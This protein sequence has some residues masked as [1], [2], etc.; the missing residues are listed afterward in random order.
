MSR[1]SA[2][3]AE[4][5]WAVAAKLGTG[6]LQFAIILLMARMLS[7]EELGSFEFALRTM[8]VVLVVSNL[9]LTWKS[10][11]LTSVGATDDDRVDVGAELSILIGAAL[12]S[13]TLMSIAFIA[14]LTITSGTAFMPGLA[15]RV[16]LT[17]MV[18][19]LTLLLVMSEAFRGLERIREASLFSGLFSNTL[20][21]VVIGGYYLSL[22]ELSVVSGLVVLSTSA[23]VAASAAYLTLRRVVPGVAFRFRGIE[24]L[25]QIR[26]S[27]P[28][29][30][31][32]TL[33]AVAATLDI[34]AVKLLLSAESLGQYATA[35]RWSLLF[36]IPWMI[37]SAV[38]R[39]RLAAA[40]GRKEV[41]KV[42]RIVGA[43]AIAIGL[44][45][46]LLVL[47][48]YFA[49]G[50]LLRLALPPEFGTMET[51]LILL[52]VAYSIQST[53]SFYGL[54]LLLSGRTVFTVIVP[55][56]QI[57][58]FSALVHPLATHF[59]IEGVAAAM[60]VAITAASSLQVGLFATTFNR[61]G[62][63]DKT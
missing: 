14:F 48:L 26:I 46:G 22:G 49:D 41:S 56:S 58:V 35:A 4:V 45:Q 38:F 47:L 30:V 24:M 7:L 32:N 6:V 55:L 57:A 31:Y 59:G 20:A 33:V 1:L 12:L 29:A 11:M 51:T 21:F 15:E 10:L 54:G 39:G 18:P 52:A 2:F 44:I 16:V 28:F 60:L 62:A 13:S 42:N 61:A 23:S 43:N 8:G 50:A 3:R 53:L 36:L 25:R 19:A 40:I 37:A 17:A 63:A 27:A 5:L 9:G 34:W